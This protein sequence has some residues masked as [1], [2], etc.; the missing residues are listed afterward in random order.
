M[1]QTIIRYKHAALTGIAFLLLLAPLDILAQVTPYYL[2][3]G[4]TD[5]NDE[6]IRQSNPVYVVRFGADSLMIL[7]GPD[8]YQHAAAYKHSKGES[9]FRRTK[10][11]DSQIP[12][13]VFLY[14]RGIVVIE[15]GGSY[16]CFLR[17][18]KLAIQTLD[19]GG[20][21]QKDRDSLRSIVV[22][23]N[24]RQRTESGKVAEVKFKRIATAYARGL[25]S[26]RS[27]P[28]L[29]SDIKKWS[30]NPTTTV[31]ISDDNYTIS[32][33]Y[34]GE[35]LSKSIRAFIKYRKDGKCYILWGVFGYESLG[36]GRFS[37][38]MTTFTSTYQYI[39]APGVGE[40]R[41]DPGEAQEIDCN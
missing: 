38:A 1:H 28:K 41:L 35:A 4:L 33:N 34:L 39:N 8:D 19:A 21:A 37:D 17:D 20:L 29:I 13:F 10:A 2:A 22:A 24:N 25:R 30:G 16:L 15:E 18:R 7:P 27:D 11:W 3:G 12:N 36:G 6:M 40:L 9:F 5:F 23:I 32:R 14:E 31:Y 26:A